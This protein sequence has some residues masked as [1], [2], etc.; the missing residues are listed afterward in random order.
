V[1]TCPC[2][3]RRARASILFAWWNR[4]A[5]AFHDIEHMVTVGGG[6]GRLFNDRE[7]MWTTIASIPDAQHRGEAIDTISWFF[8][9]LKQRLSD[10]TKACDEAIERARSL[11]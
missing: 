11:R 9:K 3:G 1:A 2:C 5:A 6:P 8:E 7:S 10:A 4:G